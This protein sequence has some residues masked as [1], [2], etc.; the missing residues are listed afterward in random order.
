M[1]MRVNK[2]FWTGC[3]LL[4]KILNTDLTSNTDN[5]TADAK[6]A[7]QMPAEKVRMSL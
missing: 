4:S 3:Q 5:I 7:I 6:M 2:I 1:N